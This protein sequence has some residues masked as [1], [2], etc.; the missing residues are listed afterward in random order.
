MK[1]VNAA[2][3]AS[4]E[5]D[6]ATS[7]LATLSTEMQVAV[8]AASAALGSALFA[9]IAALVNA[10][11][12]A[13][14][15]K[16]QA[17]TASNIKLAEFRQKWID[18]LR[19]Q[20]VSLQVRIASNPANLDEELAEDLFRILM[21]MNKDDPKMVELKSLVSRSLMQGDEGREAQVELLTLLQTVVKEEWEV[22]K[23]DLRGG[24]E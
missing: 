20:F 4:R 19:E 18:R 10:R 22:V 6:I 23:D 17:Q 14:N 13:K 3:H 1:T 15:A 12:Q 16:L 11:V 24:S 7:M 21:M 9:F 5:V 2:Q 8:I